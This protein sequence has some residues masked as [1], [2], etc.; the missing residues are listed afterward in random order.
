MHRLAAQ[1]APHCDLLVV[2]PEKASSASSHS[3]TLH[4]PIRLRKL[5]RFNEEIYQPSCKVEAYSCSGK[6]GDC[7]TIGLLHLSK[8]NPVNLVLAGINHGSNVAEDLTYSGTVGAAL[9]GAVLGVPSIALSF[10]NASGGTLSEAAALADLLLSALVYGAFFPWHEE[11]LGR[12]P[13]TAL[14]GEI[15]DGWPL[16]RLPKRDGQFYPS[17]GEWWPT[18]TGQTPCLNVNLPGCELELLQGIAW[19]IGGHREYI[20]VVKESTDPRGKKYYWL[21]GERLTMEQELPGSDTNCLLNNVAG[22]TPISYDITNYL[23]RPR[24]QALFA[25]RAGPS[26]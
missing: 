10:D 23:D 1:L 7:V 15:H 20:D 2:C 14:A 24:Y 18:A 9:E 25:E 8:D 13:S 21:V 4:K 17:P 19:S 5:P 16:A 11:A 3:V 12:L 26:E 22:V 6:P